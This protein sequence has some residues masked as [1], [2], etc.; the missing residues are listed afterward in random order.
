MRRVGIQAAIA[1]LLLAGCTSETTVS[2]PP[3]APATAS[4]GAANSKTARSQATPA[5]SSPAPPGGLTAFGAK[6]KAW[7][8][9]HE[10]APGYTDGAAYLPLV[11]GKQPKYYAVLED[12]NG[13]IFSYSLAF[14]RGTEL[15]LA[16][17]E[18]LK[19]FP[20][21]AKFDLTDKG[22]GQC[23]LLRVHSPKVS[24][25]LDGVPPMVGF[26]SADSLDS[27]FKP[28]DVREAILLPAYGANG[29]DLGDC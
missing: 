27:P 13:R 5:S 15:A 28:S 18:V 12:D 3:S 1:I 7:D 19:Q 4:T 21:G 23:L 22:Q 11:D 14:Q 29:R 25:V 20:E 16:K 17:L 2:S 10:K 24:K 6:R 8:S 26:Y 9:T